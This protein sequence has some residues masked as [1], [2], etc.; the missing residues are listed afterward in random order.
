MKNNTLIP[1]GFFIIALCVGLAIGHFAWMNKQVVTL[2]A[3][4]QP[5]TQTI[6]PSQKLPYVSAEVGRIYYNAF[7]IQLDFPA[8]MTKSGSSD[9]EKIG[10]AY[11]FEN[12]FSLM[13]ADS[14]GGFTY[15]EPSFSLLA[16]SDNYNPSDGGSEGDCARRNVITETRQTN[17]ITVIY[18]HGGETLNCFGDVGSDT[19]WEA[20]KAYAEGIVK[21]NKDYN[22]V[23]F[24]EVHIVNRN[25]PTEDFGK[26]INAIK[27][28]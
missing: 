21:I 14:V 15:N 9:F 8:N 11:T 2:P 7:G 22:G 19:Q 1:I 3:P 25:L 28:L 18:K 12:N 6:Q 24:S 20:D 17:G 23:H 5:V 16:K 4:E 27:V 13:G 26:M 10:N